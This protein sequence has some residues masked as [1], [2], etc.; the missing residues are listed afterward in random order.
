MN[1][2]IPD[3]EYHLPIFQSGFGDGSYP[4][5]WGYDE[6][7]EICQMVIQFIDIQLAYGEEEEEEMED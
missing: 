6:T 1:W 7:G 2:K 5:Y 4:V 3:T